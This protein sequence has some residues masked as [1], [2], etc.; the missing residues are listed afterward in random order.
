MCD[1]RFEADAGS[2][3]QEMARRLLGRL[4]GAQRRAMV[5]VSA[6]KRPNGVGMRVFRKTRS[7]LQVALPLL[8][9]AVLLSASTPGICLAATRADQPTPYSGNSVRQESASIPVHHG[10]IPV[11]VRDTSDSKL[12]PHAA[13][14][15]QVPVPERPVDGIVAIGPAPSTAVPQPAEAAV[16]VEPHA[17]P[18]PDILV[19]TSNLRL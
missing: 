1:L 3:Q 8:L 19:T 13:S 5:A 12:C 18:P 17:L 4:L 7:Y 15:V 11:P 6:G 16:S 2:D 10:S 14:A 9:S